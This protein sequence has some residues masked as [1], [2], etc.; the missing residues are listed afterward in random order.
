MPDT[1]SQRRRLLVDPPVQLG[2]MR[3]ILLHWLTFLVTVILILPL[4]RAIVLGDFSTPLS[5]RLAH[6]GVEAAI[7][8]GLFLLLLPYFV[9]DTFRITNRFAGPM[10]RLQ[11]TIRGLARGNAFQPIQFRDGDYWQDV[12]GDFN[13]MVYRL[14]QPTAA[15]DA[16]PEGYGEERRQHALS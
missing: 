14:Q 13:R 7:L 5:E 11:Q 15:A 2:L 4:F 3:R 12:A 9:Y 8:G 1:T 10:Y 16:P 6:A